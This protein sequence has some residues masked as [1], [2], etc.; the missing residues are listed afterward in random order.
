[1]IAC[2]RELV[3]R[4]SPTH[5][6]LACDE[7]CSYLEAQFGR[8]G[9]QVKIHRHDIAGDHLQVD[10]GGA[11]HRQPLLL[12][13]HFDTVYDVGTIRS[14][15]WREEQGRLYGPGVFDMKSGIAQMM[16]ALTAI[17][18]TRGGLARPVKVL[19]V[20]DEEGGSNSSR[21]IT[22][23]SGGAMLRGAG[24]RA[25]RSG[26]SAEDGSQRSGI[27]HREGHWPGRAFRARLR[28]GPERNPRT[29]A[30]GPCHFAA[31][32][33]QAGHDAQC[34]SHPWRNAHQCGRR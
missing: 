14:M 29:R 3:L 22:E 12:L 5:D 26:R 18:E 11:D 9:G 20:S 1:M 17:R 6:K 2:V 13:G 19:L 15:P 16:F 23:G 33:S 25:L 24:L 30:S 28:E 31:H 27:V 4:E 34:R 21:T 10:F 7:L 32:R 8:I